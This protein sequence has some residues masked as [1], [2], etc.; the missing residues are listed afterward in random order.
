MIECDYIFNR[1]EGNKD[2]IYQPHNKMQNISNLSYI[3]AP[4]SFG[5]STLLNLIGLIFYGHKNDQIDQDLQTR[6]QDLIESENQKIT[7]DFN[8]TNKDGSLSIKALKKDLNS[9]DYDV[10]EIRDGKKEIL[11]PIN[12]KQKFKLIY[13]IP[14]NPITRLKKLTD[15]IREDQTQFGNRI[16]ILR[17]RISEILDEIRDSKDPDYINKLKM[18]VES[19][20]EKITTESKTI[21]KMKIEKDNYEKYMY[22]K[23]YNKYS[24]D[25]FSIQRRIESIKSG[26]RKKSKA[27]KSSNKQYYETLEIAKSD[28]K[29]IKDYYQDLSKSL[30]ELLPEKKGLLSVWERLDF[31]NVIDNYK[32]SDNFNELLV[33]FENCL[34]EILKEGNSTTDIKEIEMY[35]KLIEVMEDYL[36]L[37]ITIYPINKT[38][39]DFYKDIKLTHANKKKQSTDILKIQETMKMITSID[40]IRRRMNETTLPDLRRYRANITPEDAI[41]I[42]EKQEENERK[43]LEDSLESIR[44][45]YNHYKVRYEDKGSPTDKE[46]KK[47]L[48]EE[49]EYL[50]SYNEDQLKDRVKRYKQ[51][52]QE[53]E[54]TIDEYKRKQK[55]LNAEI[56]I[57]EKKEEHPYKPYEKILLEVLNTVKDMDHK[58]NQ[59]YSS[60]LE[61]IKKGNK[62]KEIKKDQQLYNSEIFS[63]L[64]KRIGRITIHT[65]ETINVSKVDLFDDTLIDENNG[66]YYLNQMGTG[67]QQAAFLKSKLSTEDN[68]QIIAM[69]D[70]VGTMDENTLQ[71]VK[72]ELINLYNNNRLLLGLIVQ[73]RENGPLIIDMR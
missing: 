17:K 20:E 14:K 22:Y 48:G 7:F 8:I 24:E 43:R 18:T 28:I 41:F 5:K 27:I 13:D 52:I 12:V 72:E 57:L 40:K 45:K 37:D 26:K 56:I 3:L 35:E 71:Q 16:N 60:Y 33:E 63:Y 39:S 11:T 51:D 15:E 2:R 55:N 53:K 61:D 36:S 66:K 69:F 42:K 46:L 68:R 50:H 44:D 70:E 65:G 62:P 64:G 25:I 6:I 58:I 54:S 30:N 1:K 29:D 10:F 49:F 19:Y 38:L 4:N 59:N 73:K 34:D 67:Q 32:F 23:M 9:K 21:E 47:D 31:S